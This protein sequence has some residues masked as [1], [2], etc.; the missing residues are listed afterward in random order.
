MYNA[1]T[2]AWTARYIHIHMHNTGMGCAEAMDIHTCIH[3][4][5]V[6]TPLLLH[7]CIHTCTCTTQAWVVLTPWIAIE[8]SLRGVMCILSLS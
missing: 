4:Y 1:G 3:A 5:K 7:T 2:D 8:Y 6:L